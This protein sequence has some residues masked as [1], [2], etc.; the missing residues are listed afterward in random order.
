MSRLS[1]PELPGELTQDLASWA[2]ELEYEDLDSRV[3]EAVVKLFR[4]FT[5]VALS[6]ASGRGVGDS[7]ASGLAPVVRLAQLHPGAAPVIG[8]DIESLPQYA[9]VANGALAHAL[10][11]MDVHRWSAPTHLSP[12]V[13]AAALALT[14]QRKVSFAEFAT[15]TVI[16][17][18]AIAKIGMALNVGKGAVDTTDANVL[19]A[20]LVAAKLYE[21]DR[22]GHSDV[23]GIGAYLTSGGTISLEL[24]SPGY[25]CRPMLSG[26][27]AGTGIIA[28][29]LAREGLRGS[30]RI[31]EAP[32]GFL[33]ARSMMPDPT[34]LG[35]LGNPF[36]VLRVGLKPYPTTRYL[37]SEI[38]ALLGIASEPGFV[39]E[40]V[41]EIIIEKPRAMLDVTAASDRL[42][43]STPEVARLSSFYMAA[44]ALRH[45][46]ISLESLEPTALNDP[47]TVA[48]MD[49]VVCRYAPDLESRFSE[50]LPARVTVTLRNGHSITRE[51]LQPLGEPER[52]LTEDQLKAKYEGLF[53]YCLSPSMSR[54]TFDAILHRVEDLPKEEDVGD[55][56][57][58]LAV[59]I[60]SW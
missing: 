54:D 3:R 46:R 31:L 7:G 27:Q 1:P 5:I 12:T 33:N 6:G 17:F 40:D 50:G 32:F 48:L 44:V 37:H 42:R 59:N 10:N 23:L 41:S 53:D 52:P 11:L 35:S 8:T 34:P 38:E 58:S 30:T 43:P 19:G 13:F 2:Y 24:T 21:L 47:A 36:E 45:G 18:E 28:A 55:L 4:D 57:R 51:I 15:A 39:A 25:W 29:M 14:A 49:R 26:W 22:E 9:A 56:Y 20:A 16:G 60:G